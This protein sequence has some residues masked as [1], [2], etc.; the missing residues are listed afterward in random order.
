MANPPQ[1][2]DRRAPSARS[3]TRTRTHNYRRTPCPKERD[4]LN[5]QQLVVAG[6]HKQG[7]GA[8]QHTHTHTHRLESRVE[9]TLTQGTRVRARPLPSGWVQHTRDYQD[10]PS[11]PGTWDSVRPLYGCSL[12]SCSNKFVRY[13]VRSP[14]RGYSEMWAHPTPPAPCKDDTLQYGTCYTGVP[15]TVPRSP[16]AGLRLARNQQSFDPFSPSPLMCETIPRG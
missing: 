14:S 12:S 6:S 16:P 13:F 9:S 5:Q 10:S 1:S 4:S 3:C 8:A 11:V 2:P 7:P 15:H